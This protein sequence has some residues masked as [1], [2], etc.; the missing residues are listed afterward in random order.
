MNQDI[1]DLY[2]RVPIGTKAIVL[3]AMAAVE[4]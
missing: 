1:V 2:G 4:S 3:P